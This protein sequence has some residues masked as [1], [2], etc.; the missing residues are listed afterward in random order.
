VLD[1]DFDLFPAPQFASSSIIQKMRIS[2][3]AQSSPVRKAGLFMEMTGI[4]K[5]DK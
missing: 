2:M 3:W 4:Y 5:E 1:N